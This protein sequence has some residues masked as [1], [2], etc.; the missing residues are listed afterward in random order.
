[1]SSIAIFYE[2]L[3]STPLFSEFEEFEP[4]LKNGDDLNHLGYSLNMSTIPFNT[5]SFDQAFQEYWLLG[6]RM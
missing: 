3:Y 6:S 1:M 5:P 4:F 2:Y